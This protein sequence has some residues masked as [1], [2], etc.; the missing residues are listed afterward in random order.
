V[1]ALAAVRQYSIA[2][3]AKAEAL[4][5][6]DKAMLERLLYLQVLAI[7]PVQAAAALVALVHQTVEQTAVLVALV[8][9]QA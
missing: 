4:A 7:I 3:V 9:N 1:V 6:S 5:P 2:Q 8:F